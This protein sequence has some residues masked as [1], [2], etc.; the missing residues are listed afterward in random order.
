MW[1]NKR[2]P[3]GREHW[4]RLWSDKNLQTRVPCIHGPRGLV[5]YR[6]SS[7]FSSLYALH[8]WL[9]SI[10]GS[11]WPLVPV[12]ACF[13]CRAA[14]RASWPWVLAVVCA[15]RGSRALSVG[16]GEN[17]VLRLGKT[18]CNFC[19]VSLWLAGVEPKMFYDILL[20]FAKMRV[21]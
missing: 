6:L 21:A 16:P 7:A 2:P 14:L 10:C 9:Y 17:W 20:R 3:S 4:P 8:P 18:F 15:S 5:L 13:C 11:L 12:R 19:C 1:G